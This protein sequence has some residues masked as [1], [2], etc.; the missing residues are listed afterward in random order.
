MALVDHDQVEELGRELFVDVLKLF[1]AGDG[2]IQRQVDFVG[3]VH[4]ALCDLGHCRAERLEVVDSG[5]IRQ[6]VAVDKEENTFLRT[7]FPK[8][9]DGLEYRVGLPRA[10]GHDQQNAVLALGDCLDRAVDGDLLVIAWCFAAQV[11]IVVLGHDASL[12]L[13]EALPLAIPLP[14]F[15]R[16]GEGVKR[17]F[18][19]DGQYDP[20]SIV[21]Q[22]SVAVGTE[23]KRHVQ[24]LGIVERLLHPVADGV[25][26]ILG[27]D[28]GDGDVRLVG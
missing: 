8:T 16:A 22:E 2:L 10:R 19:L 13:A 25:V 14:E 5:L 3:F 23:G 24:T 21:G 18:L 11:Q 7:G 28:D 6:D 12:G 20:R 26:V 17:Q 15:R 4:R 9:P 27:F 1:R